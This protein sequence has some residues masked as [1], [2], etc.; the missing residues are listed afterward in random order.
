[1]SVPDVH[2]SIA[3]VKMKTTS[4]AYAKLGQRHVVFNTQLMSH[5]WKAPMFASPALNSVQSKD[6][7]KR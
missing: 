4:G 1:M 5:S 6:R 2:A 3:G 7:M